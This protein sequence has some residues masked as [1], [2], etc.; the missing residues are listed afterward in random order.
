MKRITALALLLCLLAPLSVSARAEAAP[1]RFMTSA[2]N[3]VEEWLREYHPNLEYENFSHTADAEGTDVA[4]T[5]RVLDSLQSGDGPDLLL[6]ESSLCD[7]EKVLKSGLVEDLSGH[8]SIRAAL[9]QMYEPF[10]SFVTGEDGGMYGVM[11]GVYGFG[12]HVIPAAWE[13]AGLNAADAPQS[14]EELLDFACRWAERAEAG[15]VGDIRLNALR[16]CGYLMDDRRYTLWLTDLLLDIW[17]MRYQSAGEALVFNTPEFIALAER[18]RETGQALVKAEE[19]PGS[20]SLSLYDELF[21]GGTGYGGPEDLYT[22][23]FPMRLTVDEPARIKAF[24]FLFVVRKDSPYADIAMDFVASQT[25]KTGEGRRNSRLYEDIPESQFTPPEGVDGY[26]L[27]REW[28]DAYRPEWLYFCTNPTHTTDAYSKQ[29][30]LR[31][32]FALGEMTAEE[33]AAALDGIWAAQ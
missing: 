20:A 8:Q 32:Q 25:H 13:A 27:T 14:Y 33:F 18:A 23:A 12:M 4:H 22:N 28:Q 31:S 10:Q 17:I 5:G 30:K 24:G 15:E 2:M 11:Y 29:E 3:L 26:V 21:N 7:F 19:K 6:L 9:S 16:S 1:F